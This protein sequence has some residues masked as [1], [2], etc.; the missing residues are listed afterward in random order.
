MKSVPGIAFDYRPSRQLGGVGLAVAA[1]ALAAP[2]LSGLPW[3]ASVLLSSAVLAL[4]L[5]SLARFTRPAFRRIAWRAS[6]W[7]L[8]DAGGN[9]QP[10]ELRRHA[11]FGAWLVLLDFRA[12][13][14]ARFQAV[15]AP[16][17]LD[18]DTRRRLILLLCRAEVMADGSDSA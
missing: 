8:V 5:R 6:G 3:P 16:D 18:A 14:Q 7:T 15:I 11:R 9:E 2:W 13:A 4:A 12:G 1:L 10:A 17:N